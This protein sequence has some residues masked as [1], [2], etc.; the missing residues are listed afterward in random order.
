MLISELS[1]RA[2]VS[3]ATIKYY[4][5]EGLLPKGTSTS[6]TR[7]EYGEQH[8]QR[9]R[10]I[11]ALVDVGALPL[12]GVRAIL[13]AV[14]DDSVNLHYLLGTAAYALE[15]RPERPV[16][17]P[18]WDRAERTTDELL[19]EFGWKVTEHAPARLKLTR[20]LATLDRLGWHIDPGLLRAYADSA[21]RIVRHEFGTVD[22]D[23]PR[24][25]VVEYAVAMTVLMENAMTALHRL[26]QEDMSGRVLDTAGQAP[27]APHV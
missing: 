14:D 20:T 8:L 16:G 6:P 7:A 11:R 5:R 24:A 13:N 18:E 19:A 2:D 26:A 17:D 23:R 12:A 27:D 15:P 1:E 25:E 4:I 9:L 21:A 22:F 10:L 3:I